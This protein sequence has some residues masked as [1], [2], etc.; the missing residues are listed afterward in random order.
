M[1]TGGSEDRL[2]PP[3]AT[4][5]HARFS[6]RRLGVV[7]LVLALGAGAAAC[8]THRVSVMHP[9][10]TIAGRGVVGLPKLG[11]AAEELKIQQKC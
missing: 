11:L 1:I 6:V 4:G 3:A 9:C 2:V 5:S 10:P 7:A 8:S